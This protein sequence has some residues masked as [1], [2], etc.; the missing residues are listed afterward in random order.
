MPNVFISY[1]HRDSQFVY[2]TESFLQKNMVETWIDK[3]DIHPGSV[4][5]NKINSGICDNSYFMPFFSEE[6]FKSIPCLKELQNAY[7]RYM[8]DEIKILPVVLNNEE[9]EAPS[10]DLIKK[11]P[12]RD[13]VEAITGE[14]NYVQ[15]DRFDPKKSIQKVLDAIWS[16][17]KVKFAL[18]LETVDSVELQVIYI[19]I[20][21]GQFLAPDFL[22]HWD[23]NVRQFLAA[24][25]DES[26]PIKPN[27]PIAFNGVAPNWLLSYL[28]IPLF[29]QRSVFIYNNQIPGYLCVYSLDSDNMLG[30][31]L[32]CE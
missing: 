10:L 27:I 26:E 11:V 29:N 28:I 23:F 3:N 20:P 2:K 15:F 13:M 7:R 22:G 4:I 8:N 14:L 21:K 24:K 5:W 12:H 19:K 9:A 32:K 25:Q 17:E 16:N 18:K 6:Y 30:K 1:S 31:I